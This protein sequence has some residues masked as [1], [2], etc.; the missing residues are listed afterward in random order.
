MQEELAE[1]AERE[2]E[3]TRREEE[4]NFDGLSRTLS[5]YLG[6]GATTRYPEAELELNSVPFWQSLYGEDY[7]KIHDAE[8]L[9]EE[10]KKTKPKS[11]GVAVEDWTPPLPKDLEWKNLALNDELEGAAASDRTPS[12]GAAVEDWTSPPPRPSN[13]S[14][15]SPDK[16]KKKKKI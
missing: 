9:A 3:R 16:K 13:S 2:E 10:K 5:H 6:E 1:K 15:K 14:K 11:E 4:D 7:K 12:K 8:A